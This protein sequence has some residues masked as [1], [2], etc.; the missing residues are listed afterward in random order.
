[1]LELE[2]VIGKEWHTSN[3]AKFYVSGLN[4]VMTLEEEIRSDNHHRYHLWAIDPDTEKAAGTLFAV[5]L[6]EGDKYGSKSFYF[7]ICLICSDQTD[8]KIE[9][10]RGEGYIEG[11]FKIIAKALTKTKAPRLMEWW[12]NGP[13]NKKFALACADKIN[14]RGAK[15]PPLL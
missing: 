13:Q 11:S 5:F 8:K 2:C 9:A 1:M 7:F 10:S 3:W 12:N 4:D 15:Q 14:K 6:Q